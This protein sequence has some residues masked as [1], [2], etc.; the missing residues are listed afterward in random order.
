M[1]SDDDF[2]ELTEIESDD[3]ADSKKKQKATT[4]SSGKPAYKIK[5]AL[6]VPRATTYTAQALYGKPNSFRF[7]FFFFL[8]NEEIEQIHSCDINL[9]PEYQRGLATHHPTTLLTDFFL[10]FLG[11]QDVVWPETKQIGI[12]DSIFRNF[13]IPPVIFSVNTYEDGSETKTCIDGKQRLTSIH[14]SAIVFFL[15]RLIL[16]FSRKGL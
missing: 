9:E 16:I 15:V 7:L 8:L 11:Y 3:Y 5:N 10:F 12:I 2:S 6:K 4:S 14:K 13:Y 1:A